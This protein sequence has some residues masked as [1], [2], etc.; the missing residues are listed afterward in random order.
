MPQPNVR[1]GT[2]GSLLAQW[3]ASRVQQRLAERFPERRFTLQTITATADQRPEAPLSAMGGEGI[4]VK[5]L[6]QALLAREIDIAVHSLK[7]VPLAVP[8]GLRVAAI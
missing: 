8:S 6:E 3:Q 7:D 5:E 4:F 1:I 2:R